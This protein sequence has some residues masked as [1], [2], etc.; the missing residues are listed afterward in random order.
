VD[1]RAQAH[2]VAGRDKIFSS[3]ADRFTMLQK[4]GNTPWAGCVE[5]RM[6]PYDVSEA[7]PDPADPDTLFVPYFWPDEPDSNSSTPSSFNDY[8]K[9]STSAQNNF[10]SR[11]VTDGK[12]TGYTSRGLGSGT[13]TTLG[14]SLTKGPNAG[15]TL[16]PVIRLTTDSA[17]V[18]TAIN[19]MTAIGQ[20]DIPIGLAWGWHVLTP[21]APFADGLPYS[22]PHLKKI[23]ILM[24]D[25]ENTNYDSGDWNSSYYGGGGFV[26]QNLVGLTSGMTSTQRTSQRDGRLGT[27]CTNMKARGIIIYTIRV[28]VTSG[29]SA[30]LQNCATSPDKFF[31][32]TDV[33]ALGAAFDAIAADITNLRI[34]H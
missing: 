18:K 12:Y 11:E 29:S 25:G 34:A 22:T 8:I 3:G 32:V 27:L 16:Q 30:L 23:V 9:D 31:D 1:G 20:T 2:N 21:N 24:T 4:L 26:W 33:S 6:Q 17:S 14:M 28:E 13:F 15:C 19:N 10:K 5:Q 7:P